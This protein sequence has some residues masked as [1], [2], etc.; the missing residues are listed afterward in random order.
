LAVLIRANGGPLDIAEIVGRVREE[1]ALDLD[2]LRGASA[3]QR[4]SDIMRHQV[5]FGRAS[6]V[7]RGRYRLHIE[8]FSESTHWRCLHWRHVWAQWQKRYPLGP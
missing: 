3:R 5:R 7:G 1:E 4:V 2:Q 6:V 8:A